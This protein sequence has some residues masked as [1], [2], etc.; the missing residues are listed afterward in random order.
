MP[1]NYVLICFEPDAKD[2]MPHF[3]HGMLQA[4]TVS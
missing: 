1:G 4:F 2:G 3:V